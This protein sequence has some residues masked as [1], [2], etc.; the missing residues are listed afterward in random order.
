[1]LYTSNRSRII[2]NTQRIRRAQYMAITRNVRKYLKSGTPILEERTTAIRK[3]ESPAYGAEGWDVLGDYRNKRTHTAYSCAILPR[4]VKVLYAQED[5][6]INA[7]A[8]RW[9][10]DRQIACDLATDAAFD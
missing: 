3:Y 4:L 7:Q 2:R 8:E 10:L 5:A 1:M 6:R 9:L